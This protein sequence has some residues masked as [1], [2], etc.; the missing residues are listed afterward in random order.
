LR[1][2]SGE[3]AASSFRLTHTVSRHPPGDPLLVVSE[4]KGGGTFEL[5]R[6]ESIKDNWWVAT[7]PQKKEKKKEKEKDEDV[8]CNCLAS[9]I[10]FFPLIFAF[11][12]L[13]LLLLLFSHC[14]QQP[15]VYQDGADGLHV[16]ADSEAQ[17][18]HVGL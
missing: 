7:G 4:I 9:I 6:T 8:A 16:R 15:R 2:D 10:D 12:R 1:G 3:E 17:V 13:F 18:C 14:F 5:G 11:F